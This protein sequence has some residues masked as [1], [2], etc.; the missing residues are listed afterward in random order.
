MSRPFHSFVVFAEMRT[1]SNLL[2]SNLNAF[3]G[4]DC[5]GEAFN[6]HFIGYPNR[7]ELL[8]LT[9]QEREK[10]PEKLLD[11]VVSGEGLLGFRFF[12]DHDPRI[13]PLVLDDPRCAKIILTRDPV[14]S[15]VSWKIVHQ[16]GQWKLTDVQRRK[17]A[18][19]RFDALEFAEYSARHASFRQQVM[20]QLQVSGQSAFH[21]SYD[22][23][24]SVEVMNGLARFLGA[25]ARIEKL[26][27]RLKVQNPAPLTEK[28]SNPKAMETALSRW[29][30]ERLD[31]AS[32]CE[33]RRS[34]AVPTYII[35]PKTPLIFMPIKGSAERAVSAW[36]ARLDEVRGEALPSQFSQKALR[37]WKRAHKDHRSFSV[38]AH[39]LVR[40]HR[41]Y[42]AHILGLGPRPYPAIRRTLVK[43]YG[44][45]IPLQ[46]PDENYDFAAH[47]AGFAGFLTF[48][49]GNLSAQTAVRVDPAWC[50][51]SR[52]VQ[53]FS[54]FMQP[55]FI[56]REDEL[57]QMLPD[58][59]RRLGHCAP[60]DFESAPPEAPFDLAEI[61][62][63]GIEALAASAYQRD[64]MIFGF[65]RWR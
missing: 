43:R 56:L 3:E 46:G 29:S 31:L 8:G 27:H 55:D 10:A 45:P 6:P 37:Q 38:V 1:G 30:I 25:R 59:A 18:K 65:D 61:Y 52:A 5:L 54:G 11:R 4:I 47:R 33:P 57:S 62:D 40:A 15:Y 22:D 14:Q 42:C 34:A 64:Y 20:R 16:T 9:V 53:D 51:Q 50:T 13:L 12:H 48:L 35:G 32:D 17:A 63:D 36:M 7:S 26:D 21:V 2:E 24:R 28:V 58:L 39:P 41:A 49:K 44:L 19:V 60:P 23:L